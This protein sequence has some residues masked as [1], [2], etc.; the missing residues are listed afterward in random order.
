MKVDKPLELS[1]FVEE[2]PGVVVESKPRVEFVRGQAVHNPGPTREELAEL[3][4]I[5]RGFGAEFFHE[6]G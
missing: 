4:T 6:P 1:A 5:A 3:R 2:G